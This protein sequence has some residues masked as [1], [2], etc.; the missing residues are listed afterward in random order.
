MWADGY[1]ILSVSVLFYAVMGNFLYL[2]LR[3]RIKKWTS[4]LLEFVLFV[5]MVFIGN[6]ITYSENSLLCTIECFGVDIVF[7]DI[8]LFVLSFLIFIGCFLYTTKGKQRIIGSIILVF[9]IC[10]FAYSPASHW[11][12]ENVLITRFDTS[13]YYY[14]DRNEVYCTYFMTPWDT[15]L[16]WANV[17]SF[18]ALDDLYAKDKNN[19]YY[20]CNFFTSADVKTF[21]IIPEKTPHQMELDL[22]EHID[23]VH[24]IQKINT[25]YSKDKNHVFFLNKIVEWAKPK[26]FK[27]LGNGYAQDGDNYYF[28]WNLTTKNWIPKTVLN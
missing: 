9:L 11:Y 23:W 1:W 24:Y 3:R 4:I 10:A 25:Y 18:I 19:V 26:T 16:S 20:A 7:F 21:E 28:E 13:E 12:R 17:D 8:L 22:Q 15:I 27:S 5:L 6:S 2:G 14:K